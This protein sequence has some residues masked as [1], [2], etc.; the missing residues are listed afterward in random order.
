MKYIFLF[1]AVASIYGDMQPEIPGTIQENSL[2]FRSWIKYSQFGEEGILDEILSRLHLDTGYFVEFGAWDGCTLSNTRFLAERGWGGVYIES[3]TDRLNE[4]KKNCQN[5]SNVLCLNEFVAWDRATS[6]GKTFDQIADEF[7]PDQEIDVL[8]I[9]VDGPDYLILEGLKRR[10]KIIIVEGGICWHPLVT[11][12][13]PDRIGTS[14]LSQPLAVICKI[15]KKKGYLPVCYTIN[16][17]FVRSDL[18]DKFTE[19]KNDPVSLWFDSWYYYLKNNPAIAHYVRE[20]R[21]MN[22]WI[23]QFDP[24]E[25]P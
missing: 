9:D 25:L 23:S 13:V 10:P 19:I 12:R 5:F 21:G 11:H 8:S 6:L 20:Q 4:A 24:Y 2:L 1:F 3:D 18:F 22:P 14:Y 7:F 15:A 16:A 17:F